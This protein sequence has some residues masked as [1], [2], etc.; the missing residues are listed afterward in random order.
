[1]FERDLGI[2]RFDPATG[3]AAPVPTALRGATT[4]AGREHRSL[5]DFTGLALRP[6]A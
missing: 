3:V 2:W 5:S 4:S 6:T 1:V